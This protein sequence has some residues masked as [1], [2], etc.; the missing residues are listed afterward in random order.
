M[1]FARLILRFCL[2]AIA[3]RVAFPAA[4][5]TASAQPLTTVIMATPSTD[6]VTPALYAQKSGI[7][8]QVRAGRADPAHE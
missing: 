6:D 4:Y 7:F 5:A 2:A 1:T 8:L 3:L